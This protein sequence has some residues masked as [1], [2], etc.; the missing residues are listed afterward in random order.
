MY[1]TIAAFLVVLVGVAA[2]AGAQAKPQPPPTTAKPP[3]TTKPAQPTPPQTKPV[4]PSPARP[5]TKPAQQPIDRIYVSVNGA[6]QTGGSDFSETV[7]FTENA[8]SG[9]FSTDYDVKSGPAFNI[10]VG[11]S[12]W[13]N[14]GVGVGVTRFSKNT[15]TALSASVPHPFFFNRP[16]TVDGEVAGITREELAVHIQ[17]RATFVP[18]RNMQAVVFAGPSFFN[19]KQGIV[20]DFEITEAYPFDTA[21]FSRGISTEVDES[22]VGVNVGADVGYFFTRQVGVGGSVQWAGTTIDAPASGSTGT[23]EIKAGGFQAGGG[24]RLRF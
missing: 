1:R 13:R 8:E 16:R 12:L 4:Q 10:S 3:Q 20:N 2:S 23:L 21:A 15:P 22:K 17:A 7:T 19:V 14:I 6:F 5:T 18:R 9:T 11:A 24:L